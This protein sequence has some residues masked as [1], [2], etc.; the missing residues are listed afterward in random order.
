[1]PFLVAAKSVTVLVI[2]PDG[3]NQHSESVGSDITLHLDRHSAHANLEQVASQGFSV[4]AA[5]LGYAEQSASDLLVV[6]AYS[7][8]RAREILFG[9]TTR[10]LLAQTSMPTFISR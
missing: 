2:D 5:M 4:A 9:G 10:T 7:H 6:G 8:A 3:R 1:M